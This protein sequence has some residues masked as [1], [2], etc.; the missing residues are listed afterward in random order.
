[1]RATRRQLSAIN[2]FPQSQVLVPTSAARLHSAAS[3]EYS[4]QL[5]WFD[6]PVNSSSWHYTDQISQ[7]SPGEGW[8][9]GWFLCWA[10]HR[11]S[12]AATQTHPLLT[13]LGLEIGAHIGEMAKT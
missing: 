12:G 6:S 2:S 1:M 3:S 9:G 5:S 7:E 8:V 11:T 13:D 10:S 4:A